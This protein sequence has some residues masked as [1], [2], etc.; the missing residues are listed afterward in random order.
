MVWLIFV[1]QLYDMPQTVNSLQKQIYVLEKQMA[2]A[3]VNNK[4]T[5]KAFALGNLI[6]KKKAI[7]E[8]LKQFEWLA[9]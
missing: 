4:P 1:F 3:V 6:K 9:K 8:E 7:L 5:S 2:N